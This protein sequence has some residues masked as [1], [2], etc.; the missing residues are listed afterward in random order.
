M[1]VQLAREF[2]AAQA[3]D[4]VVGRDLPPKLLGQSQRCDGGFD[5]GNVLDAREGGAAWPR[6]GRSPAAAMR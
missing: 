3:A 2:A 6:D 5:T 4:G 1:E